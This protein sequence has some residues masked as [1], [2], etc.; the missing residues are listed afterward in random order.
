MDFKL[1]SIMGDPRT[2]RNNKCWL[3]FVSTFTMRFHTFELHYGREALHTSMVIL[4]RI[5]L[6][7]GRC[8]NAKGSNCFFVPTFVNRSCFDKHVSCD[9]PVVLT[10]GRS[11]Q[12]MRSRCPSNHTVMW[13]TTHLYQT[14]SDILSQRP[15]IVLYHIMLSHIA[16]CYMEKGA[17][18]WM[19]GSVKKN[20]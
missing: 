15:F 2:S 18:V 7:S 17:I 13:K 19:L 9:F 4:I 5:Q 6:F 14:N 10:G 20:D 3:G 16:V 12:S 8:W 1:S 11:K